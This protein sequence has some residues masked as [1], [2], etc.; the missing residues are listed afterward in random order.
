V[1]NSVTGGEQTGDP[2]RT[3]PRQLA[4]RGSV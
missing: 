2:L 4:P 3:Q 1:K